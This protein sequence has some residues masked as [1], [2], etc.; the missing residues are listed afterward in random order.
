MRK[1]LFERLLEEIEATVVGDEP[2]PRDPMQSGEKVVGPATEYIKKALI[3]SHQ[4]KIL[5]WKLAG[6]WSFLSF[7][8]WIGR[9]EE[10]NIQMRTLATEIHALHTLM[11]DELF[12][13]YGIPSDK[14]VT[15][16]LG[17]LVTMLNPPK[18]E[19]SILFFMKGA[20]R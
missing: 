3:L 1:R 16:R 14:G 18:E 13:E 20:P 4:K 8:P 7:L 11:T 12:T 5:Y 9:S 15:I 6:K 19:G 2:G 17:W 10:E